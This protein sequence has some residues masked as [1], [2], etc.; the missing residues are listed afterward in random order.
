[1]GLKFYYEEAT[2]LYLGFL[3]LVNTTRLISNSGYT[4]NS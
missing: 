4:L 1:M 2:E 3:Q